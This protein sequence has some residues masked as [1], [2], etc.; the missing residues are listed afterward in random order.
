[1]LL[2]IQETF[3][4]GAASWILK[5]EKIMFI[6]KSSTIRTHSAT[7]G[8]GMAKKAWAQPVKKWWRYNTQEN[9]PFSNMWMGNW[10]SSI[11]NRKRGWRKISFMFIFFLYKIGFLLSFLHL[12]ERESSKSP[13]LFP[14]IYLQAAKKSALHFI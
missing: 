5:T 3:S 14:K 4:S 11:I 8:W 2:C 6:E 10:R 7:W 13:S 12:F 9:Y 1:M